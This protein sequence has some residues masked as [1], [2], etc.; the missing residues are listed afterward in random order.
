MYE[1]ESE[2]LCEVK[3]AWVLLIYFLCLLIGG[4][5][6]S[7][8]AALHLPH[9]IV[10]QLSRLVEQRNGDKKD[11]VIDVNSVAECLKYCFC[12]CDKEILT[13]AMKHHACA[14]SSGT[15]PPSD[16]KAPR[17]ASVGS[18]VSLILLVDGVLF[19]AH[20]G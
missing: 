10:K 1:C 19:T 15:D 7:R 18:C 16:T 2:K 4:S 17:F 11:K 14:S 6:A 20:C 8:Y 13:I 9:I 5:F 12:Q 3:H